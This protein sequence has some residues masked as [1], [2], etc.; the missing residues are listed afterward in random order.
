MNN[1]I[2][3]A[4]KDLQSML[5]MKNYAPMANSIAVSEQKLSPPIPS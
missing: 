5:A 1:D 2:E 3:Q 4:H